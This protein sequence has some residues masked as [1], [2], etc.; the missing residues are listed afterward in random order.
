DD[1]LIEVPFVAEPAGGSPPDI[2]GEMPTEFLHPETHGLVRNDD[3]T[4]RQQIFDHAQTE[5][6]TKIQPHGVDNH[7]S[8]KPMAA[9]KVITSDL[10]HAERSHRS[11]ADRLTL[12]C[13][14]VS[15]RPGNSQTSGL[16]SRQ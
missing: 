8:W 5:R 16:A 9:I 7:F 13:R 2:I 6:K 15:S 1:N 11:I 10:G 12:R 14:L 3:P 4:R